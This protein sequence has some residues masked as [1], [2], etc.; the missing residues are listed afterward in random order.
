MRWYFRPNKKVKRIRLP[1]SY[2]SPEFEAAWRA[3]V[4]G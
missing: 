2:G 3:C 1:D 4:A